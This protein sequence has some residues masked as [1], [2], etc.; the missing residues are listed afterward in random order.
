[1]DNRRTLLIALFLLM[2]ILACA[3]PG[4][5]APTEPAPLSESAQL[6]TM[7]VETVTAAIAETQRAAPKPTSTPRPTLGPTQT[8]T[9]TAHT[10]STGSSL[11]AQADGTMLFV[12]D[13]AHFQLNVSPGWLPVRINEQEY[14]DAFSL[15]V[16]SDAAVQRALM[17]IKTLDPN[18]F[19][20]FVYDLQDGHMINGVITS[21]NFVWDPQG[22]ITLDGEAG[23]KEAASKL[24]ASIP[25]LNV[26]SYSVS[27]TTTNGIP[28]GIIL[29]NI[30]GKTFQGTDVVLFQ[31][32]VYL[33]LPAGTLVVSFTTEQ[34]FKDATL[35]F[36]DTM[37]ETI[38]LNP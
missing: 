2:T 11:T 14:Y 37:V 16:A 10:G 32:Q 19:R 8:P 18:T 30:P 6:E 22:S 36:F 26:D 20:L 1:M 34:N 17:N 28:I 29:S 7:V 35:P 15:P 21:V 5:S 9:A 12:D 31:K 25:N 27:A 24:S 3:L 38:K 4:G 33:N 13:V 23:I